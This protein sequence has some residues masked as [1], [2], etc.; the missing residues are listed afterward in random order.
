MMKARTLVALAAGLMIAGGCSMSPEIEAL[1]AMP[2][3]GDSFM[4]ALHMEYA[5]LAAE[6]DA[7]GDI[8]SAE[9]F[10]NKGKMAAAGKKVGPMG[11]KE[12]KLDKAA[13]ADIEAGRWVLVAML[14]GGGPKKAPNNAA[15]AQAS[16]DCW[17]VE[18]ARGKD[19]MKAGD[20]CRK[21]FDESFQRA[22]SAS[23]P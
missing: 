2:T 23:S 5:R 22:D 8:D 4:H 17:M 3:K 16:F 7:R 6:A 20:A 21:T 14:K 13:A 11:M 1:Q 15:L 18:T 12:R 10:Y 19:G 9:F